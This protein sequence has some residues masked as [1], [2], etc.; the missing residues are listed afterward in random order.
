MLVPGEP[1]PSL[2]SVVRLLLGL[3]SGLLG[4]FYASVIV[5]L[6]QTP[7]WAR[8]LHPFAAAGRLALT[9]YLPQTVIVTTLVYAYGFGLYGRVGA[10]LSVPIAF[11][12]FGVQ[13]VWS[14]WWVRRFRFGPAEWLWRTL[15]Y[16]QPQPLRHES[17]SGGA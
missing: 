10:L 6:A 8:R 3:G 7:R 5:L 11:A 15:T 16:G 12:V 14:N 1:G 2:Q 4:L 13:V 9:N 17:R